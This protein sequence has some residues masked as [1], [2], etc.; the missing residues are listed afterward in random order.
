[1]PTIVVGS[2]KGKRLSR[3]VGKVFVNSLAQVNF[4]SGIIY[5]VPQVILKE[6]K[7]YILKFA[8]NNKYGS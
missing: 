5:C 8:N 3:Y 4:P 6:E 2:W 1:M 7:N